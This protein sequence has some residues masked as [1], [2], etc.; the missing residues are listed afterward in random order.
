[1][2]HYR[3]DDQIA[4]GTAEVF[5][6]VQGIVHHGEGEQPTIAISYFRRIYDGGGPDLDLGSA[7]NSVL[8]LASADVKSFHYDA[9]AFFNEVID[10]DVHRV[11]FAQTLSI[12]HPLGHD[13]TLSGELWRFTQPFLKNNAVGNLWALSYAA[14]KNLVFDAGFNR[15]LTDT[16]TRWEVFVGFTYLLP[17]RANFRTARSSNRFVSGL[18]PNAF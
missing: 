5:F 6:G 10:G 13:F 17:H 18:P 8:L 3:A 7:R 1:L 12:S 11:Q 16:S 14:R 15:G 4:T 2:V 9:N